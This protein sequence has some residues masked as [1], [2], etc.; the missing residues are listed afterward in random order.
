MSVWLLFAPM[1]ADTASVR[2][3]QLRLVRTVDI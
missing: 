2:V 1:E 3:L